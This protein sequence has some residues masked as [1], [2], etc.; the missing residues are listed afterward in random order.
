MMI[1]LAALTPVLCTKDVCDPTGCKAF[2]CWELE[3]VEIQGETDENPFIRRILFHK[4][5]QQVLIN[6]AL[7][8]ISESDAYLEMERACP[9]ILTDG[10]FV[11]MFVSL[12]WLIS[13]NPPKEVLKQYQELDHMVTE[14]LRDNLPNETA[15]FTIRRLILPGTETIN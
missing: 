10:N 13:K 8:P 3:G 6:L 5:R 2:M 9:V 1:T 12:R 11:T 4:E 14:F 7:A 15:G